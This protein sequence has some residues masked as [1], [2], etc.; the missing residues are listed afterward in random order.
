MSNVTFNTPCFTVQDGSVVEG[1]VG[2]FKRFVE[3][4][5]RPTG[6]GTKYYVTYAGDECVVACWMTWGGPERVVRRFES[7]LEALECLEGM[8][9]QEILDNT[10]LVIH[11]ERKDAEAELAQFLEE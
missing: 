5:T 10:E 4:T 2:D 1:V 11:L 6:V 8:H 9:V 7:E 3:T